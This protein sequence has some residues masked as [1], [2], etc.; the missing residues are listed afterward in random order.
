MERESHLEG[1][2]PLL[3]VVGLL[4]GHHLL[5]LDLILR[6]LVFHVHFEADFA[7]DALVNVVGLVLHIR[8]VEHVECVVHHVLLALGLCHL[9]GE[10]LDH[11]AYLGH[12][13]VLVELLHDVGAA[14]ERARNRLLRLHGGDLHLHRRELRAHQ[15]VLLT[16]LALASDVLGQDLGGGVLAR[17]RELLNLSQSLLLLLLELVALALDLALGALERL[18]LFFDEFLR[19]DLGCV[20]LAHIT[21][22]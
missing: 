11:V 8:R 22:I 1:G 14:L 13:H 9:L 20:V 2:E 10:V 3:E 7:E 19:V 6:H 16:L 21:F 18:L 4:L 12:V 15:Q 17:G 5:L